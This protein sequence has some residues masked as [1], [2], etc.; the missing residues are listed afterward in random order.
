MTLRILHLVEKK[1]TTDYDSL[2]LKKMREVHLRVG[3]VLPVDDDDDD[4]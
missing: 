3:R 2:L 4:E 1:N